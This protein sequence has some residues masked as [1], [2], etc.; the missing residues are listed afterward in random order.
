MPLYLDGGL[1]DSIAQERRSVVCPATEEVIAEI[2]WAG[3]A[4]ANQALE[5]AEQGFRDWSK[6]P[7]DERVQAMSRLRKLVERDRELLREIVSDEQGKT[8]DQASEDVDSLIDS[9]KYYADQ[10]QALTTESIADPDR[11]YVHRLEYEPLGVVVAYLAWNFPL[12]NLGFKLGPALAS[13]CSIIIK[14]SAFTPL[15][16][17]RV[18]KLC[19]EAGIPKGVVTILAGSDEVISP[20]LS[21]SRIP[22]MV[23]L[24]GSSE[25]GRKIMEQS[26]TSIKRFSFELGGNAPAIVFGD[27][28]LSLAADIIAALKFGNTGQICVAPNRVLVEESIADQ[29]LEL[30]ISRAKAVRIGHGKGSEATMGPVM[31]RTALNRI[32]AAVD[33][34][35]AKGAVL[36]YSGNG[37]VVPKR[38]YYLQPQVLSNVPM[39]T[40]LWKEEIFGPVISMN[41]FSSASEALRVANDTDA[42][43][44][45]YV[46]TASS[47]I[48][49]LFTRELDFGEVMVNG[50][51]Y[52]IHLPHGGFK[53]SGIGHDCSP[54]ALKEYLRIKRV[55]VA[56]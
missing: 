11:V 52:G 29:F 8:L 24:I 13:G 27:A 17:Y 50:V 44:A 54:L 9:L 20:V 1:K 19:A 56:V 4:D 51:S 35:V 46:F 31:N 28:D 25:T 23:T 2:A 45:S 26:A 41:R 21:G 14:P 38:G 34:A 7:I 32:R 43:L 47:E 37:E 18:G 48:I 5:S 42:G 12:L 30:L 39:D 36:E 22:S 40:S 3:E 53:Q 16:A 49:G 15:S 55:S 33:D 6:T 10:I